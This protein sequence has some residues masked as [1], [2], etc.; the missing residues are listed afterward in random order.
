MGY[1]ADIICLL[2]LS[3]TTLKTRTKFHNIT[4]NRY[5]LNDDN[6]DDDDNNPWA[7]RCQKRTMKRVRQS[8]YLPLK[9]NQ[10]QQQQQPLP[11]SRLYFQIT[12]SQTKLDLLKKF[13]TLT[14]Q[15][16]HLA[17]CHAHLPRQPPQQTARMTTRE[18]LATASD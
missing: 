11:P 12:Q 8:D 13:T 15:A 14:H 1:E 7:H 2:I 4:D 18:K 17:A 3:I 10:I 16:Y 9:L 6:D 5:R